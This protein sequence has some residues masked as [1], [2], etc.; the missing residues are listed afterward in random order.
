M[1]EQA[2]EAM[3]FNEESAAPVA[4]PLPL[5]LPGATLRAAREA[6]SLS[7]GDVSQALKFGVRQIEALE[8]DDFS[9]LQGTTFIRGFVRSYARY[10]R[11]DE[12]PLLTALENQA[13]ATVP[14][15]RGVESMDAEMPTAGPDSGKRLYLL[16]LAVLLLGAVAWFAWQGQPP[17]ARDA[18]PPSPTTTSASEV[19]PSAL[20]Q[21]TPVTLPA[22]EVTA[23]AA[24][25]AVAN[26]SA[27]PVPLTSAPS[28]DDRQLTFSFGDRSWVEVRDAT[29]RVV[30]TGMSEPD[31]RQNVRGRP[32]F[33]LVIGNAQTV[34]LRYEDRSID[35][36][37]YIRADVARLTLDDNTKQ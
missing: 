17:V 5:P 21:P 9:S 28:P 19:P 16:A 11:L 33:Q 29:Q 37:P 13:P 32:P 26:A 36:Q 27:E 2:Q 22:T 7:L 6:H 34:K 25:P 24:E 4:P 8:N 14:E 10:L 31:T 30:Y 1:S 12:Q 35:L 20:Q 3:G 18:A 15:V 23:P